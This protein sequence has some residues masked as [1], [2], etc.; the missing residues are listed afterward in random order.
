[1]MVENDNYSRV[2]TYWLVHGTSLIR[3]AQQHARP[4]IGADPVDLKTGLVD[5]KK[6]LSQA[7]F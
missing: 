3:C 2:Q 5:A 4:V 6:A 7:V 1:M